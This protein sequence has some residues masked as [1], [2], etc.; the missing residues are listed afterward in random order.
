MN[1]IFIKVDVVYDSVYVFGEVSS[2]LGLLIK[3]WVEYWY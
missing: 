1:V 3:V 2:Y